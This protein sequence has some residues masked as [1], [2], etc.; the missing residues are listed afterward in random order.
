MRIKTFFLGIVFISLGFFFLIL[1]GCS[2]NN[3]PK[4]T[5]TGELVALMG[6]PFGQTSQEPFTWKSSAGKIYDMS[7]YLA[8]DNKYYAVILDVPQTKIRDQIIKS[9]LG[10]K[11]EMEVYL[12]DGEPVNLRPG[13]YEGAIAPIRME[14]LEDPTPPESVQAVQRN[15][16]EEIAEI[17]G[18][19]FTDLNKPDAIGNYPI[20]KI[21]VTDDRDLLSAILQ[22]GAQPNVQDSQGNT[23]LHKALSVD[24]K[25]LNDD[26]YF[27][28]LGKIRL[29]LR[30]NAD[31]TFEN[32]EGMMP[33]NMSVVRGTGIEDMFIEFLKYQT[34]NDQK[35]F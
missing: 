34:A 6:D 2:S 35:I 25:V 3:L 17:S 30:F 19:S 15:W 16:V 1:Q 23:A 8:S 12:L 4:L 29:L 22:L 24:I 31:P 33:I 20:H 18:G 11:V 32:N 13:R 14:Y 21:V 5:L 7:L 26:Q 10:V 9:R 28:L 27:D